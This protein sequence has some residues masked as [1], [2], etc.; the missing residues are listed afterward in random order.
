MR[1]YFHEQFDWMQT[2]G[3]EIKDQ[4]YKSR[5]RCDGGQT[6]ILVKLITATYPI[7]EHS[8][9]RIIIVR[10]WQSMAASSA[11][12]DRASRSEK[13]RRG[14]GWFSRKAFESSF[15]I[16][17]DDGW[18]TVKSANLLIDTVNHRNQEYDYCTTKLTTQLEFQN[19]PI[20]SNY[21]RCA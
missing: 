11:A 4:R 12:N 5:A 14:K 17:D 3:I 18:P 2:R 7:H 6:S 10:S 16:V 1:E 15:T 20:I 13:E 19:I 8:V 21:F 9:S